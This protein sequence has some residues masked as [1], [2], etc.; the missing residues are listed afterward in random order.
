MSDS[1]I[2]QSPPKG[3]LRMQST[4]LQANLAG[5]DL[6][7]RVALTVFAG[8]CSALLV[9]GGTESWS[10]SRGRRKLKRWLIDESISNFKTLTDNM[11]LIDDEQWF[12]DGIIAIRRTLRASRG[13]SEPITLTLPDS[14]CRPV[15]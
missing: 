9:R 7:L 15:F 1:Q 12:R 5:D 3:D 11:K 6:W 10:A 13:R 2:T 14:V 8:V 4:L